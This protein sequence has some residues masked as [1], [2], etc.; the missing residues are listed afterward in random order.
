[1]KRP[2]LKPR[3]V[4]E[5]MLEWAEI[6][7]AGHREQLLG[8]AAKNPGLTGDAVNQKAA[9]NEIL[10]AETWAKRGAV[11]YALSH[12]TAALLAATRAPDVMWSR[13]PHPTFLVEV[14][15]A[16]L[17]AVAAPGSPC[18]PTVFMAVSALEP[19]GGMIGTISDIET[20][21][22]WTYNA[23]AE[24]VGEQDMGLMG[25]VNESVPGALPVSDERASEVEFVSRLSWRLAANVAAY[26][27][28]HRSS[29]RQASKMGRT[30]LVFDVKPPVN[31]SVD[32][33]FRDHI[34]AMVAARDVSSA[35][36]AL[37]H[38]V[39]GHW[40]N[41]PVGEGRADRRLT[42]VRPHKRGDE[43]LGA[44]VSRIARI[45]AMP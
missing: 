35:K 28:E 29:V 6:M 17:P 33:A 36:R 44:V 21:S 4:P 38:V 10:F 34:A 23:R 45:S 8:M 15:R 13:L 39:R 25:K 26:V 12:S 19:F 16:F 40:R 7:A 37:S 22:T 42:W 5:Q 1:M 14:P 3:N 18:P 32:R 31:V 24:I 30:P 27:T 41:Q 20:F 9:R 2:G 43:S 11:T